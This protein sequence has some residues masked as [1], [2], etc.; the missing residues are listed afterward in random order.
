MNSLAFITIA[1]GDYV[2]YVPHFAYSAHRTAPGSKIKIFLDAQPGR[3]IRRDIDALRAG[4]AAL[5]ID[6]T[7][8]A[9]Y[10]W[11]EKLKKVGATTRIA[12]WLLPKEA[13]P[14]TRYALITDIDIFFLKEA[15]TIQAW[16][17]ARMKRTGLAFSNVLRKKGKRLTGIHFIDQAKYHGIVGPSQEEAHRHKTVRALLRGNTSRGPADEIFLA[18]LIEWAYQRTYDIDYKPLMQAERKRPWHGLHL[19]ASRNGEIDPYQLKSY[20]MISA[21]E[22]GGQLLEIFH[23]ELFHDTSIREEETFQKWLQHLGVDGWLKS[24]Q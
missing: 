16:H 20:L 13:L 6:T 24:R 9:K 23:D 5:E 3:T 12:R 7:T 8:L 14:D 19:G 11:L 4:G 22:A 1:Y 15:Q 10:T 18:N 21:D 2:K 17:E